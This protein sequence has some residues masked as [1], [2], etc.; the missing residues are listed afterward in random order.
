LEALVISGYVRGLS[1][2]DVEAALAEALGPEAALSR[3][4]VSRVCEAIKDEF[5]IWRTRSLAEVELEYLY[6]DASHF[7]MHPGARAEPVLCAWGITTDGN[8]VLLAL[9]GANAESTDAC[10]GFLRELVA[11]GL[12]PPLLVITDGAPGLLGSVE[13]V[14]PHSLRQRCLVHRA[15]NTL[16]KVSAPD[17]AAVKADYWQIFDD[18]HA[19]PGEP[20]VAEARRRAEAFAAR[21]GARS[22]GAVACVLDTL[23]E[24][25]THLRFPREH[26]SRIRH[27]NLIERTFGETRRRTKVIGRL[28]GERSC[29]SLVWAVLDRAS[30]G[31][32]GVD[33]RPANV[34]LLQQLRRALLD[35]SPLQL[36]GGDVPAEPVIPAA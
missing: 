17:Q 21:W 26:W 8:P 7:R 25:T 1:T 12:R 19:E 14:F 32:R 29:L 4:T 35:P 36:Q 22:P 5:D 23:P 13:Q 15:R 20:A 27:S 33:Q 16:A 6:L 31:W 34:R 3:S 2:R 9:D 24:L 10:L 11:R 28:P 30:R 18:L